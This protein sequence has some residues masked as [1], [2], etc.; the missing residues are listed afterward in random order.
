MITVKCLMSPSSKANS[1]V[2]QIR[3]WLSQNK[4]IITLQTVVPTV[5]LQRFKHWLTFT[6][7]LGQI[8]ITGT[9]SKRVFKYHAVLIKFFFSRTTP[10][11]EVVFRNKL[12]S[13]LILPKT[14]HHTF[15]CTGK[16]TRSALVWFWDQNKDVK[17]LL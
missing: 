10:C 5:F 9:L 15:A 11:S 12:P 14:R 8:S 2:N 3:H 7:S 16:Q 13:K 1:F 17:H 6:L 4:F